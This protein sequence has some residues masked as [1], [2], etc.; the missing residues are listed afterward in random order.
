M[1]H[2]VLPADSPTWADARKSG[3]EDFKDICPQAGK[4]VFEAAGAKRHAAIRSISVSQTRAG[5]KLNRQ[6]REWHRARACV[7]SSVPFDD[8]RRFFAR[9]MRT[10][11]GSGFWQCP[12]INQR[13][14]GSP[15]SYCIMIIY[16]AYK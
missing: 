13:W 5:A 11:A 9:Q 4:F 8:A 6:I 10:M 1:F 12:E 2:V 15:P 7:A 14:P 16:W 3:N